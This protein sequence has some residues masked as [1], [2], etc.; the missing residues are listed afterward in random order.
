MRPF[1]CFE[2][3]HITRK[4]QEYQKGCLDRDREKRDNLKR[5]G[6]FPCLHPEVGIRTWDMMF[7]LVERCERKKDAFPPTLYLSRK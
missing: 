7:S 1:I 6:I 3:Y 2:L 5:A 4:S